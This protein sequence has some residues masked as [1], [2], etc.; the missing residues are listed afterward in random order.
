M[1]IGLNPGAPL[2]TAS[3]FPGHAFGIRNNPFSTTGA[4]FAGQTLNRPFGRCHGSGPGW[5][6]YRSIPEGCDWKPHNDRD[7]RCNVS[8]LFGAPTEGASGFRL[9]YG[10]SRQ[11]GVIHTCPNYL[12]RAGPYRCGHAGYPPPPQLLGVRN[13]GAPGRLQVFTDPGI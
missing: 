11:S 1:T 6:A 5:T 7:A 13:G 4:P 2:A 12:M 10:L 3:R 9:L 8:F